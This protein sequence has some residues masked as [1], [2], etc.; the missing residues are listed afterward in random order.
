[1]GKLEMELFE[2]E[3]LQVLITYPGWPKGYAKQST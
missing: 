3:I 2:R 1:M